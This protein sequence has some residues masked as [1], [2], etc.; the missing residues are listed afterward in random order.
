MK[1]IFTTMLLFLTMTG[2]IHAQSGLW[3][4]VAELSWF[5]PDEE[6]QFISTETELA[7]LSLMALEGRIFE[8]TTFVLQNDLNLAGRYWVPI[9]IQS[10]KFR[11]TFNGNNK[12][13][14]NLTIDGDQI[15]GYYCLGLFGNLGDNATIQDLTLAAVN[16]KGES[17]AQSSS[18]IG[19][20]VGRMMANPVTIKN[21]HIS[22]G[23]VTG[24]NSNNFS[25]EAYTGGLIGSAG[26]GV[27]YTYT[28]T[29]CTNTAT[30][31][32]GY[33]DYEA[34]TGGIIGNSIGSASSLIAECV[35]T[36]TIIGGRNK[37]GQWSTTGG[38][39][40][41]MRQPILK[42]CI[43]T[44]AVTGADAT[45]T[46]S[47][48][49]TGG[50][51]GLLYS[52]ANVVENSYS[53][54]TVSAATNTSANKNHTGGLV[55]W[56]YG[57]RSAIVQKCYAEG[58]VVSNSLSRTGGI[59]GTLEV[60]NIATSASFT[61]TNCLAVQSSIKGGGIV[62]RIIGDTIN[63]TNE[64]ANKLTFNN[65]YAYIPTGTWSNNHVSTDSIH[66]GDW[67]QSMPDPIDSWDGSV[68]DKSGTGLP[69]LIGVE[70]PSPPTPPTPPV[71]PPTP[72]LPDYMNVTIV[73]P[74][75]I[76]VIPAPGTHIKPRGSLMEITATLSDEY[77]G[78]EV[79]FVCEN[80]TIKDSGTDLRSTVFTYA[81]YVH[82]VMTIKLLRVKDGIP[83]P[84][85]P[86]VGNESIGDD[87]T[88][89]YTQNGH[90]I[91]ETE[92]P[93]TLLICNIHGQLIS[94]KNI[95]AGVTS[96]PLNRGIYIIQIGN[97]VYKFN[98]SN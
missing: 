88:H 46:N 59:V 55:G 13:I 17:D 70:I 63:K 36:G 82:Q 40:G 11:G 87:R 85:E 65:N 10:K 4:E 90:L 80:D 41:F 91:V 97:R 52:Y 33:V 34:R 62:N 32:G 6:I 25:S 22:G 51:V 67:T 53:S 73:A 66:G 38:I 81:T 69:T 29:D 78:Q 50:L 93:T 47:T 49:A 74:S 75:S 61:I 37:N 94:H 20:L 44:G 24:S 5:D 77:D 98:I 43:N 1:K 57:T 96:L 14:T 60:V 95:P 15:V 39:I 86:P 54:G 35:N 76:S 27:D 92:K 45:G 56:I 16:V 12:T 18:Y 79:W 83:Q 19:G 8:D 68:W 28:I 30:V 58:S 23:T 48:Y 72:S 2:L 7:G 3:T 9:G 31:T 21:C 89:V 84:Y 42:Q 71:D 26:G 64:I